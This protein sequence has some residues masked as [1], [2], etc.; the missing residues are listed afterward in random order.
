[1]RTYEPKP[2]VCDDVDNDCNGEP[3]DGHPMQMGDPPPKYAAELNDASYPM[4]LLP[5]ESGPAWAAFLNRGTVTW[6]RNELWLTTLSAIKGKGSPLYDEENWPAWDVAATLDHDV[7]PGQTA[8]FQWL[9]RMP[10]DA[11][12]SV[13]ET[14]ALTIPPDS[15]VRCPV[16]DVTLIVRAG[17]STV[18]DAPA[19]T[20]SSNSQSAGSCSASS[21]RSSG[22]WLALAGLAFAC[23]V[24]RR[25]R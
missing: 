6:K 2:E 15:R 12:D 19:D 9:V 22:S 10:D 18:A 3:D 4:H 7:P 21:N 11:T 25:Q 20:A 24:R 14:F 5:G 13:T 1:V 23:A 17:A 8:H 16:S